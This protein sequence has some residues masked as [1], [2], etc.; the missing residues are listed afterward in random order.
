MS[1]TQAE[2]RRREEL[3]EFLR[4]RRARLAPEDVNL[5]ARRRQRTPGLRREDVAGRAGVSVAWYI[6]LEQARDINPSKAVVAALAFALCLDDA[7]TGHLYALTGHTRPLSGDARGPAAAVLQALVDRLDAPAYCTDALTGVLAWNGLAAD[8]FG[9]YGAWPPERRNLLTMLYDDN[10][11]AERLVDRDGHAARVVGTFRGRSDAYLHDPAAI[12]LVDNLRR[13]SES[14]DR[15]W[16]N[17]AV[18][19]TD[20]DT[21][22]ADYPDGRRHYTFVGLQALSS[23]AVRFNAYLPN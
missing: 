7:D 5:P 1:P 12:N 22:A 11:F 8:L 20:T 21:L 14:F 16:R 4:N 13:L 3:A 9:D 23:G 18:R 15:A 19:R 2:R 10:G 17:V 6:S